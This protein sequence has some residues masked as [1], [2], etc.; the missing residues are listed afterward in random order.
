MGWTG[1][2]QLFFFCVL[3]LLFPPLY[4]QSPKSLAEEVVAYIEKSESALHEGLEEMYDQMPGVTLRCVQ[5]SAVLPA[6]PKRPALAVLA[7]LACPTASIPS[8]P[9]SVA[10]VRIHT[11]TPPAS[12]TPPPLS[13]CT[14]KGFYVLASLPVSS[15][16]SFRRPIPVAPLRLRRPM[17]GCTRR[18]RRTQTITGASFPWDVAQIRN[19]N[20]LAQ[21]A[22][23]K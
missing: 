21:A 4:S 22:S 8:P 2:A 23:H 19:R 13:L 15:L 3:E 12:P 5:A 14:S 1:Y 16:L 18:M 7:V 17:D 20:M 9:P 10:R 6:L 11:P